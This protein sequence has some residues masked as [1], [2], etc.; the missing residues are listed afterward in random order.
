M[1]VVIR[2][3]MGIGMVVMVIRMVVM[4][5]RMVVMGIGMVV[6]VMGIR[7]VVM[8]IRMVVMVKCFRF[9]DQP[10]C[11]D[12]VSAVLPNSGWGSNLACEM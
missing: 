2:M 3:V 5:I 4:V 10:C 7:M 11:S 12:I 8:V 9:Q 1:H 6:M